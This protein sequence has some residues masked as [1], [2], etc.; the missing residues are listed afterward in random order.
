MKLNLVI[1]IL[2]ATLFSSCETSSK[3]ILDDKTVVENFIEANN[4]KA[5][6]ETMKYLHSDFVQ[7]FVKRHGH[8][9]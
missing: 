8:L 5:E 6:A 1:C 3:K 9:Q 2:I 4:E 7:L